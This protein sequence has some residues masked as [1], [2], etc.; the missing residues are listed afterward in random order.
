MR[1]FAQ[2]PF[3][4][5]ACIPL[6]FFLFRRYD[7][8]KVM[9]RLI[10]A[11]QY[12]DKR[13]LVVGGGDSAVEA[14]LGLASQKGNRVTL[15]YRKGAFSR[16]KERNARRLDA[17]LASG[18]LRVIFHSMPVEFKEQS[19][20]LEVN[21]EI[22]EMPNDFVWIFAGGVAPNDFLRSIGVHF[23]PRDL[24]GEAV[25]EAR[26]E[27]DGVADPDTWVPDRS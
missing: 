13:I 12:V 7:L 6:R 23:G 17:A 21:G 1:K 25:M 22:Q 15:S 11:D 3:P 26:L 20:V 9:Y 10:E 14:A 27:I 16:I 19:V 5:L 2:Q 18:H 8:P 4:D 24:T